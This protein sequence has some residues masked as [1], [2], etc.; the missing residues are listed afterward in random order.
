M[1]PHTLELIRYGLNG[2]VATTI[3][4]VVLTLNLNVLSMS[5]AGIANFAAAL[6]GT[7][8]SFIGSRY[9]VFRQVTEGFM[10]QGA[11]FFGLYAFFASLHGMILFIWT[12]LWSLDFR[13][14]FLIATGLQVSLGYL[15]SKLIV[16]KK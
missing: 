12:D 11:K 7:T 2:V 1:K 14:G 6:F 3:H 8:A 15:G 16:F 10:A 5:S 13:L 4:Y 9:F